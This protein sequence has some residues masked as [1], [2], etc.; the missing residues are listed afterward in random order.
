MLSLHLSEKNAYRRLKSFINVSNSHCTVGSN[1]VIWP[2]INRPDP[3]TIDHGLTVYRQR[4]V[5]LRS[6]QL[7]VYLIQLN[8]VINIFNNLTF[9]RFT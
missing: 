5:K 6:N 3:V 7:F 2:N 9:G 1:E 4:K 8:E